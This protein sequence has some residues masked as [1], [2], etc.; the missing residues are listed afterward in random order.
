MYVLYLF[1]LILLDAKHGDIVVL[2]TQQGFMD[3]FRLDLICIIPVLSDTD[4]A[5]VK[6]NMLLKT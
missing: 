2:S 6:A 3:A 4:W 1:V 5:N